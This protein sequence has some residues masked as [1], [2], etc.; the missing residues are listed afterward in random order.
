MVDV[1]RYKLRTFGI[2]IERLAEVFCDNQQ[3]V[4]NSS[5]LTSDLNKIHNSICCHYVREAQAAEIIWVV[6]IE[7]IRN[8]AGFFT[9]TTI[10]I[11]KRYGIIS[12]IPNI[13]GG[14]RYIRQSLRSEDKCYDARFYPTSHTTK[15]ALKQVS[16]MVTVVHLNHNIMEVQ[17]YR[18]LWTTIRQFLPTI[19]KCLLI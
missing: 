8:L 5:I 13:I 12:K 11:L 17:I 14:G 2:T 10:S 16:G 3:V 9:K 19:G 18:E 1:L 15:V 6:C 4:K 7:D